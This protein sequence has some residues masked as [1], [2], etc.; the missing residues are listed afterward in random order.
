[1]PARKLSL[2]VLWTTVQALVRYGDQV[3]AANA[4]GTSRGAFQ[5]RIATARWIWPS[6]L[7]VPHG[8]QPG[9]A[10]AITLPFDMPAPENNSRDE[11]DLSFVMERRAAAVRGEIGGP[12]IPSIAVPPDGFVVRRN[13]GQY[14][15]DGTLQRQWVESGQGTAD[16]YEV[17]PGHVVKGE[18]TLLDA[19]GN[20]LVQW[21]KTK[22][23]RGMTWW[24]V[25]V[26]RSPT[27]RVARQ[28]RRRQGI[29][30]MIR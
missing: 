3:A 8:D 27:S 17:P 16:G 20:V 19:N 10:K 5:S 7:Q 15:A 11:D 6:L 1:M 28:C 23:D 30:T 2:A 25:S 22:R 24:L 26:P 13:S 4:L 14:D 21:I 29:Q 9:W 12:P 18:S